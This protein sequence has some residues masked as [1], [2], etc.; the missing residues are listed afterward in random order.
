MADVNMG[1]ENDAIAFIMCNVGEE[2]SLEVWYLDSGCSNH[3]SGNETLFSF[4]DKSSKSEIKM[5]NNGTLLVVGK[6]S[7]MVC[8]KQGE[9]KEIKNVYFSPGM[10]HNLMSIGQIIQNGYKVLMENDTCV[11]HERDGSKNLLAVVQMTKNRMFPLRIETYFSSQVGVAPPTKSA[12]RSVIED[13][14]RLWHLRYCH[15]GYVGLN[16]LSNKRMVEIFS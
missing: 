16:L 10:K 3:M 13:P 4:I 14:S 6:G 2:G 8:T 11:I 15:L 12:L 1:S 7:I 9:K 5:G